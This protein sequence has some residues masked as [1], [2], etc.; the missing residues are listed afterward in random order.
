[1]VIE[2]EGVSK[3]LKGRTVLDEIT[4]TCP[5][6]AVVG[7]WG[8]NGSGKTMLMR[9]ISGLV[10]ASSGSVCVE[11]RDL[12]RGGV[13]PPSL[14]VMIESPAFLDHRTGFDNLRLLAA[15][16]G[17]ASDADLAQALESVGLPLQDRRKFRAY[18]LGMRQ[19]LGLAAATM[20]SPHLVLLDEP[21]NALDVSGVEMVRALVEKQRDEGATVVL[22]SHDK[23]FLESVANVVWMMEEGRI[24]GRWNHGKELCV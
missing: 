21:T 11:G 12:T 1:M 6:R 7:L 10:K 13:F 14:G 22:S 16:R 15:I 4:L 2:L 8:P 20:E 23:A 17:T 3:S 5:S 24:V 9:V 18:S 19:R